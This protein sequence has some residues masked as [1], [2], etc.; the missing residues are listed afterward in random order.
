MLMCSQEINNMI[1]GTYTLNTN[2][3]ENP[4]I[5]DSVELLTKVGFQE[6]ECEAFVEKAVGVPDDYR[7]HFGEGYKFDYSVGRR[8]GR[9]V[10]KIR[11]PEEK[12]A[13]L[14]NRSC[15]SRPGRIMERSA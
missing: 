10:L 4:F 12:R 15:C 13:L 6:D 2:N 14:R 1:N 7:D 11:I 9:I 3:R 8:F 5:K